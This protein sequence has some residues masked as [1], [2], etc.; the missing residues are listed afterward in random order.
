MDKENKNLYLSGFILGLGIL[1]AVDGIVF[2]QL[3]QWHHLVDHPN[4]P[5]EIFSDGIFNTLV[6]VLLVSGGIKIFLDFRKN[7]LSNNSRVF[8]G[9]LLTGGG[10]FNLLEGLINHHLL[11]IHHV[12]PGDPYE[13][14]Y[15]LAFL[16]VGAILVMM[17]WRITRNQ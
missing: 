14:L 9:A 3:L 6:A 15:D 5:F 8:F 16:L 1:G 2:H 11:K 4:H 13:L 12:K 17:G 7:Q 10:A